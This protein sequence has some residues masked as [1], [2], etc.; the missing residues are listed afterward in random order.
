MKINIQANGSTPNII[1]FD[2]DKYNSITIIGANGSGKSRFGAFLEEKL[3]NSFRIS[4]LK[5]LSFDETINVK[6]YDSS[7]KELKFGKVGWG[8][9]QRMT[10]YYNKAVTKEISNYNYLLSSLISKVSAENHD[11]KNKYLSGVEVTEEDAHDAFDKISLI[12]NSVLPD[13]SIKIENSKIM[14]EKS[15]VY[16]GAEM[17]D[18]ER[19]VLYFIAIACI[20]DTE[21]IIVD[22]PEVHLHKSIIIDLWDEIEKHLPDRKFIYITHNLEFAS[23][24]ENTLTI[25]M[26]RYIHPNKW[27]Y[28][29]LIE[30][31]IPA[32][33]MLELY[34]SKKDI[35][36]VEGLS[37][38]LDKKIFSKIYKDRNIIAVGSSKNVI[39]YTKAFNTQNSLHNLNARGI[40]DKDF[41]TIDE[42][43]S[44]TKHGIEVLSVSEIENV[45]L[46]DEVIDYICIKCLILDDYNSRKKKLIDRLIKL[47]RECKDDQISLKL[48]HRINLELSNIDHR[49][50]KTILSQ[51]I[52]NVDNLRTGFETEYDNM[53]DSRNL[54]NILYE[55]NNKGLVKVVSSALGL[56]NYSQAVLNFLSH[57]DH[58]KNLVQIFKKYLPTF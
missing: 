8:Q 24:R 25:W 56:L 3:Q 6:D 14:S 4:S 43:E 51:I 9:S 28:T 34:G 31:K 58:N 47:V 41:K 22:E 2:F 45:F 32:E 5:T 1:D 54:M 21:I 44:C 13:I 16:S 49:H 33:L 12:F 19:V 29:E 35:I 17:S 55:V 30:N 36:F 42:I 39:N 52:K 23:S 53:I 11:F 27:V 57:E 20:I 15:G 50:I 40:I 38:S 10:K 7:M 48:K 26:Q 46:I 18:G 37:E